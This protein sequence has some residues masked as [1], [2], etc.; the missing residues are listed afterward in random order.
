M[1]EVISTFSAVN[2]GEQL[3]DFLMLFLCCILVVICSGRSLHSVCNLPFEMLCLSAW[4]IMFV[5]IV[6]AVCM[7][8]LMFACVVEVYILILC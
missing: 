8:L 6:L 3:S 4:S 2:E 1:S 5:N 7:H